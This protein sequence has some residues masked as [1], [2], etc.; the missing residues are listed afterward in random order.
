[1]V[2]TFHVVYQIVCILVSHHYVE[3]IL[4]EKNASKANKN[5]S[6]IIN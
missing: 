2:L 3:I 1:M 6:C 4:E 5:I